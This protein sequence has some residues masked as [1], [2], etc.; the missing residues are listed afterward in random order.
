MSAFVLATGQD[1]NIGDVVLRRRMLRATAPFGKRHV[2]IH[3]ASPGFIEG[4]ALDPGDE[5][6]TQFGRWFDAATREACREAITLVHNAGELVLN[7]PAARKQA[8]LGA[9]GSLVRARGGVVIRTGAGLRQYDLMATLLNVTTRIDSVTL[10]RD[11]DTKAWVGRGEAMPDWAFGERSS[12]GTTLGSDPGAAGRRY[13]AITMRGDRAAPDDVWVATVK[14]LAAARNADLVVLV[15]V[16]RDRAMCRALADRLDADLLDWPDERSHLEQEGLIRSVYRASLCVVS[17]RLHGLVIALT[18]GALPLGLLNHD[19]RK[20]ARHFGAAGIA[21][22]S[23]DVRK[24]SG[25]EIFGVAEDVMDRRADILCQ[26]QEA[27]H[28]VDRVGEDLRRVA[29][30]LNER[31]DR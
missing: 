10:W 29:D 28:R 6:Y 8:A 9:L 17:D 12:S 30:R 23:V 15:Q 25:E 1:D 5:L 11:P 21:K 20:I 7:A 31:S 27:A 16:R 26:S 18:E 2:F 13:I 3:K 22:V 4:L 24:L 14:R 19:D